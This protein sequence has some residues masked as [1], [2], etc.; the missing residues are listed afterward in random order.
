[1]H[2]PTLLSQ[3]QKTWPANCCSHNT[4]KRKLGRPALCC[5]MSCMAALCCKN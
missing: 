3:A 4:I 2:V 1:M 5:E